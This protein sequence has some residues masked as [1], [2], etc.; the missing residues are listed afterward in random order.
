MARTRKKSDTAVAE[1]PTT[2]EQEPTFNPS[3]FDPALQQQAGEIVHAVAESTRMEPEAQSNGFASQHAPKARASGFVANPSTTR[4]TS[5]AESVGRKLPGTLSILAGDLTVRLIDKGDNEAGIGIRIETPNGR[6]LTDE[7]KDI[8]RRHV[9]GEEG[10]QTGF[11][12]NADVEMWH[13]HIVRE[14]EYVDQ[15]PPSRPV[16]IRLDAERRVEKLAEALREHS[17]DPVGYAEQVKQ[18]REQAAE[19]GRIPD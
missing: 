15:V 3:E 10:E 12:W 16:A 5:H 1:A 7:E 6:K 14:G 19:S 17:A 9:K 11:K 18:R 2:S 8:V 13:K 4:R